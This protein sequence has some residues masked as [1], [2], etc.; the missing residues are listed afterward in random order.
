[1]SLTL[2]TSFGP[3]E[4][5]APIG[6]GGMGEVYRAR[7]TKLKRDVA[8]KVLPEPFACDA[9]RMA[10]FQREAEVLAS[11]NHP[12]IAHIYGV[13]ERALAMELVDGDT[14]PCPLPLD[15]ALVYA[16]QIAEALEYAHDRGVIHRDLKPANIKVTSDGVV[17]VL[18][19]GLAKAV[20]EPGFNDGD[21]SASPTLTLGHT[22]VGV[23]MGTAAYMAPEQAA[24]A[25]VDRRADIWSFGAV[26]YEMLSGKRAFGGDSVADTL[27]T[28]MKVEP[29]WTALPQDISPS[30]QTLVR[31][32]LTKDRKQRLQAIGEA[33]IV[34][35]NPP[36]DETVSSTPITA[37]LGSRFG[38]I[39]AVVFAL[40]F[41]AVAFIQFR[42]QPPIERTLRYTIAAP[43]NSFVHSFAISPDGRLVVI[44]A[45]ING[46]Q[47]LWL[48]PLDALQAQPMP[49]T[50]DAT[51]PFWSPDN[52]Y[53]G[54]FAQGKLKKIAASGGP[55]QSLCDAAA[56]RGGSW[57]REEVIVFSQSGNGAQGIQRV[58]AAGGVP[59]DAV[60]TKGVFRYP[61]YL[62]D[63]RRFLYTDIH[64]SETSGI[65]VSSLDGADNRRILADRSAVVFAPSSPG[66]R[67]GHLLF[68]RENNLMALPFDAATAQASGDVFPFI[69]GVG[70]SL[71]NAGYAPITVS[72]NAVLLYWVGNAAGGSNQL[73]WYDRTGMILGPVGGPGNMFSPA[74]SSDEK[75]VAFTR[76]RVGA[77]GFDIW[78]RDLA[79]ATDT[80]FTAG[81]LNFGVS[82]SPKGD[83]LV[84]SSSGGGGGAFGALYQK[85]SNGS[86]SAELLLANSTRSDRSEQWS[87][88]G[89]F[90]VYTRTDRKTNLDVWVLPIG[91][92]ST[93][94]KPFAFLQ[95]EFNESQGQLSPDSRWMAYTSDE[96]GQREVYVRPFP[97]GDG[98]WKI[99]TAG[100]EQPRWR[101]DGKELF[102][103]AADGKITSVGL[104]V[105][106]GPKPSFAAD[107]PVPLFDSRIVAP[108]TNVENL[109]QYDVTADGKRFLV[110]TTTVPS[111]VPPLTVVVNW[112][113]ALKK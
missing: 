59:A 16:K 57:N 18:D 101:G 25:K 110:V 73:V 100:G 70:V 81:G 9:G 64:S 82:W 71:A 3:Y 19:F 29:D 23:V 13:E 8:L 10:R 39:T 63:G 50:E 53:I 2:G 58:A 95:T 104:K 48:R 46:K 22:Q 51:Y 67:A 7:D 54:F 103:A 107:I 111:T 49:T 35:E 12:N 24:G 66:S 5:L 112:N 30:I 106:P 90:I 77:G 6:A 72:E 42:Q 61:V 26:L 98:R 4:I 34:L 109:F 113:A 27:A 41:G 84:F 69:E 11:L 75:V 92:A 37:R 83:R 17:K 55:A 74:I 76:G 87:R 36:R 94:R 78:L 47:Q 40:A 20:E 102:Y 21:P 86:S 52:R 108:G 80:R 85:A 99:S 56:A 105:T 43:E 31:R 96:S 97:S 15:T 65:Y 14:L 38:W 33:R 79:R 91:E 60:K 68:V 44:A 62:P 88:D 89:R 28:V 93:D 45:A 1:M 32:C